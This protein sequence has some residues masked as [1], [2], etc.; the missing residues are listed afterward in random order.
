MRGAVNSSSVVNYTFNDENPLKVGN[1]Y[2]LKQNDID[3]KFTYS[4][5]IEVQNNNTN[6]FGVSPNP[7]NDKIYVS[8]ITENTVYSITNIQG[9]VLQSGVLKNYEPITISNL[10]QGLYFLR[11]TSQTAKFVKEN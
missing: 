5:I 6:T 10:Q 2:R 1:Y 9:Q 8:G 7:S 11:T 4:N 3:G